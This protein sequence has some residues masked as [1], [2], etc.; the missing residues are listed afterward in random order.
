MDLVEKLSVS[1]PIDMARELRASVESG[2]FTSKSEVVRF[3]L[4][5]WQRLRREDADRV[6]AMRERIRRS[7]DD[8]RPSLSAEE[9][10][11]Q[12]AALFAEAEGSSEH[13]T[14]RR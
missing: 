7:I 8:P 2:E 10:D 3:A 1:M 14:S 13:A 4:R 6:E 11:A 5:N 12:L 9:V